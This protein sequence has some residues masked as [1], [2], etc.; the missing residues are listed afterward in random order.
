MY[1]CKLGNSH[2]AV[3]NKHDTNQHF[4]SGVIKIQNEA[5][6]TMT[7]DEKSACKLLLKVGATTASAAV[8][9]EAFI[10]SSEIQG[11]G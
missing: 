2:I 9:V 6:K 7:E 3:G 1:Y 11:A 5:E 10:V 8:D 4:I